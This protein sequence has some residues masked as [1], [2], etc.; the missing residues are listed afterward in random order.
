VL[1]D[2]AGLT[3]AQR[4]FPLGHRFD[5]LYAE[6]QHSEAG[7][8]RGLQFKLFKHAR[9]MRARRGTA[10][11]VGVGNARGLHQRGL[12]RSRCGDIRHLAALRYGQRY[13]HNTDAQGLII[14]QFVGPAQFL[15]GC[16]A[17][18]DQ[19][20]YLAEGALQDLVA[21]RAHRV[22][23]G[24]ELMASLAR[25]LGG[26]ALDCGL[27]RASGQYAQGVGTAGAGEHQ[28]DQQQ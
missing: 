17:E 9:E 28:A 8:Q 15:Q 24:L 27:G 25:E 21:L 13:G 19:I 12:Q 18:D 1:K 14:L 23:M 3:H 26:Q 2:L 11:W 10:C 7:L 6:R 5:D 4:I 20:G 22:V 16:G